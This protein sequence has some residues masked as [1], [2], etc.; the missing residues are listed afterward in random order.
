M[1]LAKILVMT[2]I[3]VFL[4][5]CKTQQDTSEKMQAPKMESKTPAQQDK[6]ASSEFMSLLSG[7]A[8][9][10]WKIDYDVVSK[11]QGQTIQTKMTQYFKGE[12]KIRTDAV[13]QGIGSRSY[14]VDDVLTICTNQQGSW[15]CFKP[16]IKKDNV[17]D[18]EKD[19][20]QNTGKYN[21][22]A[23]GTKTVAGTTAKCYKVVGDANG[24]NMRYCFASDGIPLYMLAESSEFMTEMTATSYSKS[25]SDS[26][27]EMP[28][29]AQ[30]QSM[31]SPGGS[32]D[33]CSACNYMTGEQKDQCLASCD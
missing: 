16:D 5:S 23:D 26:D 15:N 10:E 18:T 12:K 1:K 30:I 25:V 6:G 28:A 19:I 13:T 4:I 17:A 11:A 21:I 3:L 27:F 29:G 32:P 14:L 24:V 7:K 9:L 22:V 33:T 31:P 2:A 8:N 20:K